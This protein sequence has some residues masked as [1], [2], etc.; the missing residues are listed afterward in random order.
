[1]QFPNKWNDLLEAEMYHWQSISNDDGYGYRNSPN[2]YGICC[3]YTLIQIYWKLATETEWKA[4][5][6]TIGIYS[7]SSAGLAD[8]QYVFAQGNALHRYVNVHC[9]RDSI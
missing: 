3:T 5:F 8:G 1:M 2:F 9:W 4:N 6:S 7:I